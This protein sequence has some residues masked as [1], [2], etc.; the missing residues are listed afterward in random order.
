MTADLPGEA[1][2]AMNDVLQVSQAWNLVTRLAVQ[3]LLQYLRETVPEAENQWNLIKGSRT[4]CEPYDVYNWDFWNQTSPSEWETAMTVCTWA[5]DK[6]N[7]VVERWRETGSLC[8][9]FNRRFNGLMEWPEDD[10]EEVLEYVLGI[11]DPLS[12]LGRLDED[13]RFRANLTDV[14]WGEMMD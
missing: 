9:G 7:E 8:R 1:A 14:I 11:L 3:E 10:I 2:M 4:D 13:A 6:R 12:N 5:K